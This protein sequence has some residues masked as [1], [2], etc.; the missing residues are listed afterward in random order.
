[1]GSNYYYSIDLFKFLFMLVVC[2]FHMKGSVNF[3]QRGDTTADF[4]FILSGLLLYK[5][6]L[7]HPNEGVINFTLKKYK[8]FFSEWCI[9][10]III[11]LM[12]HLKD[13]VSG[14]FHG[15]FN[16]SL[17][18]LSELLLLQDIGI[19][20]RG[21]NPPGWYLSVLLWGGAI[22]YS[23]L[24]LSKKISIKLLFPLIVLLFYSYTFKTDIH[25]P[26][27]DWSASAVFYQPF[28][29]GIVDMSLGVLL[30]QFYQSQKEHL[31]QKYL[32]IVN[33]A[34]IMSVLCMLIIFLNPVSYEVYALLFLPS[35]I[36]GCLIGN[37]IFNRFLN[38]SLFKKAGSITF[39]MLI[40]HMIVR[41]VMLH[42]ELNQYVSEGILAIIYLTMVI[43]GAILLKTTGALIS[44]NVCTK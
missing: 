18:F 10:L 11:Y 13:F 40:V 36:L 25:A 26:I 5:S 33:V 37:S 24:Q 38:H 3:I 43:L 16:Y 31:E 1:M 8:R 19:F 28:L 35:I 42:F 41:G 29:R 27:A 15:I 4:F 9:S 6:F 20:P 39:E 2:L 17:C 7:S 23:S 22:I 12:F 30:F 14:G 32:G 21:E 34:S 44:R